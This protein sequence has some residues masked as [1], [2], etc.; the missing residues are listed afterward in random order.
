M[1]RFSYL[2]NGNWFKNPYSC[3]DNP[4]LMKRIGLHLY[5]NRESPENMFNLLNIICYEEKVS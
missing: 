2:Y 3:C 5:I 1:L 4:N